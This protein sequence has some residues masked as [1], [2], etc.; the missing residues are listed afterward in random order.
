[1]E[2]LASRRWALSSGYRYAG[3]GGEPSRPEVY[4]NCRPGYMVELAGGD[5]LATSRSELLGF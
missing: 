1:M 5:G 4:W 2:G 3:L